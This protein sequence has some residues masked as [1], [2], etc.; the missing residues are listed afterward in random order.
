MDIYD[1][2]ENA[3][4]SLKLP[5]SMKEEVELYRSEDALLIKVGS[6]KR[7]VSLPYAL[8]KREIAKAEFDK[9]RLLIKFAKEVEDD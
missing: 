6:Y 5:F 8:M 2:G 3:I 9:G 7:S 1:D 4:L